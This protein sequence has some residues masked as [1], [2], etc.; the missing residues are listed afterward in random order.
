[1]IQRA[2]YD[3]LRRALRL[4]LQLWPLWLFWFVWSLAEDLW[5]DFLLSFPDRSTDA[6]AYAYHA[7]PSAAL[8][9]PILLMAAAIIA[10]WPITGPAS[11]RPRM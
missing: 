4:T 8:A 10:S 3:L 2:G 9:G 5:R 1:M 6:F 7:W 11:A